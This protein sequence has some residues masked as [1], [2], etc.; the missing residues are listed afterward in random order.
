MAVMANGG[1]VT[2]GMVTLYLSELYQRRTTRT[3]ISP[4][5]PDAKAEEVEDASA[6]EAERKTPQDA[7]RRFRP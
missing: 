2:S 3:D 7:E 5:N 6:A 1:A 4:V